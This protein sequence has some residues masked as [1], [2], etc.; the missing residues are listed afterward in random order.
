MYHI[1]IYTMKNNTRTGKQIQ[2]STQIH[3]QVFPLL[4]IFLY[5]WFGAIE[6][7]QLMKI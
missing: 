2:T 1:Y 3:S 6:S 5:D 4:Y 7:P